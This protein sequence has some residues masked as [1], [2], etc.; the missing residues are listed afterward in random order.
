MR[1]SKWRRKG[2]TAKV[3]TLQG[4][5]DEFCWAKGRR[6]GV[7]PQS[8]KGWAMSQKI[9]R[10][11]GTVVLF[12]VLL[13]PTGYLVIGVEYPAE[14]RKGHHSLPGGNCFPIATP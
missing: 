8:Q 14:A 2:L 7:A 6:V 4:L 13:P 9:L 5:K 3:P 10:A 11:P 12:G 1:G